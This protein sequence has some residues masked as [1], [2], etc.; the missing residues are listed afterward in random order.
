MASQRTLRSSAADNDGVFEQLKTLTDAIL[1]FKSTLSAI[2]IIVT[3]IKN[4]MDV[5]LQRIEQSLSA[6]QDLCQQLKT[7]YQ[8]HDVTIG[9]IEKKTETA[10][11]KIKDLEDSMERITTQELKT[12]KTENQFLKNSMMQQQRYLEKLEAEKRANNLIFY[13]VP[14][15][16][17]TADRATAKTD[18]ENA[19]LS[20]NTL[21]KK[22]TEIENIVRL[23]IRRD[24]NNRPMKV[25]LT[26]P[27]Q[28]K[29][30]LENTKQLKEKSGSLSKIFIKKD[31][32]PLVHKEFQ[33]LRRIEREEKTNQK[34]RAML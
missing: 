7:N 27:Y 1:E 34:I 5:H 21:V 11:C 4:E 26:K 6:N 33:R 3:T 17:L 13:G 22:D 20:S 2:D 32:H 8:Q 24:H 18:E 31:I 23:G 30:I 10:Q 15:D 9:A 25:T 28:R 14:E 12:L 29:D 16:N 19:S